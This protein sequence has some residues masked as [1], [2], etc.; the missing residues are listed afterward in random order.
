M[1]ITTVGNGNFGFLQFAEWVMWL[2]ISSLSLFPLV[3][4]DLLRLVEKISRRSFLF[5]IAPQCW[6]RIPR[7]RVDSTGLLL[8]SRVYL[9]Q[10]STCHMK[11]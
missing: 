1:A 10:G 11:S 2:S 9:E 7:R 5:C 8:E 3:S 6:T 4:L